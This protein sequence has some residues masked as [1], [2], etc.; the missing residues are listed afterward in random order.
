VL[1]DE[2]KIEICVAA[3]VKCPEWLKRTRDGNWLQD[4]LRLVKAGVVVIGPSGPEH[5]RTASA[6]TLVQYAHEIAGLL[7]E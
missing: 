6:A 2:V 4:C 5:C 1:L 3:G 7:S